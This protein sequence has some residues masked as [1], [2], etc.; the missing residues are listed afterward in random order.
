[1]GL[2]RQEKDAFAAHWAKSYGS[3]FWCNRPFGNGGQSPSLDHFI[4]LARGGYMKPLLAITCGAL[5]V[6]FGAL[7]IVGLIGGTCCDLLSMAFDERKVG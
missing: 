6:I 5:L 7:F 4:Q 1:M 2:T 3:C